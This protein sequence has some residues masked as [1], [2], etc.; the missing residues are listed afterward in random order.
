MLFN[1][2][3]LVALSA[4]TAALS[5]DEEG[6]RCPRIKCF[7]ALS[8]CGVKY[9]GCYDVCSQEQPGPPPCPDIPS[10]T[11][12]EPST[13][14]SPPAPCTSTG[15]ACVDYLRT[16]GDPPTAI[17]TFGGCYPACGPKPTFSPPPCPLPTDVVVT[18]TTSTAPA[19]RTHRASSQSLPT[20]TVVTSFL[21]V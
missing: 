20:P 8:L 14:P 17:L 7:D 6:S 13:T 15:T 18:L 1:S 3:T 12:P 21:D 19:S 5:A 11:A 9:G 10:T 16:C 2:L 4:A